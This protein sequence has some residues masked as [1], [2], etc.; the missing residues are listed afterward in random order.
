MVTDGVERMN[1]ISFSQRKFQISRRKISDT[2]GDSR[3]FFPSKFR[4]NDHPPRG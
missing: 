2:R 1:I 4:P 3:V